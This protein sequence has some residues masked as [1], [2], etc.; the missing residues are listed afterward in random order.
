MDSSAVA[1]SAMGTSPEGVVGGIVGDWLVRRWVVWRCR[2]TDD[3]MPG[4]LRERFAG[5]AGGMRLTRN[6]LMDLISGC[7]VVLVPEPRWPTL[8]LST[9]PLGL[10]TYVDPAKTRYGRSKRG[11][12]VSHVTRLSQSRGEANSTNFAWKS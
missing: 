3:A 2:R 4:Y 10:N 12:P 7:Q 11:A 6:C 1:A 8:V 9:V 5:R